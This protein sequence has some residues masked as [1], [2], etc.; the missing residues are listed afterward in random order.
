MEKACSKCRRTLPRSE[1]Y[2]QAS[3]PDGLKAACKDCSRKATNEYRAKNREKVNE[4]NRL[5][6]ARYREANREQLREYYAQYRNQNRETI[7]E[8]ARRWARDNADYRRQKMQRP[9]E[10]L[11]HRVSNGILK[12]LKRAKGGTWETLVGYTVVELMAHLE[13]QFLPGM[14]WENYGHRWHVDHIVP[15]AA[16]NYTTPQHIDFKRCWALDN[17]R[18]LWAKENIAKGAKL[19]KPFQPSL[20]L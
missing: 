1:F 20:A 19:Y 14:S 17:L 6:G 15:V 7:R 10:R 9:K 3:K 2:K 18:P 12:S 8:Q 13:G 16:F 4:W 5:G 11:R